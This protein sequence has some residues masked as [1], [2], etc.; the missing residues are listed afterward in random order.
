M[1][2]V[3]K[4]AKRASEAYQLINENNFIGRIE[5]SIRHRLETQHKATGTRGK[6]QKLGWAQKSH[7]DLL[8][9]RL[10]PRNGER[11]SRQRSNN[12]ESNGNG[13]GRK[14]E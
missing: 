7:M 1:E 14:I 2:E 6:K 4:E 10:S 5:R 12:S 13:K 3:R 9:I 8:R 11:I